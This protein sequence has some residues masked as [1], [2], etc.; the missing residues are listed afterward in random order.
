MRAVTAAVAHDAATWTAAVSGEVRER[1]DDLAG[2]WQ[3]RDRPGRLDALVDALDRGEVGQDGLCL[4]LGSG[5]GLA[6]ELLAGRFERTVA[7]DLSERMLALAP[8]VAPR[9]RADAA[10]LPLSDGSVSALVLV[11]ALLFPAEAARVLAPDGALIWVNTSGS[12]T[13]IHLPAAEVVAALPG[14]WSGVA[15]RHGAGTWAVVRRG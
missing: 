11:N 2:E 15:S 14:S 9:L 3:T 7:C 4:E 13:P 6:T 1:F 12:A 8:A 10:R 5:T